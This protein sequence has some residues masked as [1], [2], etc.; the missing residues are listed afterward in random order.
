MS[1][2]V[3]Y[4]LRESTVLGQVIIEAYFFSARHRRPGGPPEPKP[5]G[6]TPEG[7]PWGGA[8][9][10]WRYYDPYGAHAFVSPPNRLM[11]AFGDTFERRLER[12]RA[13][14]RERAERVVRKGR[15]A[16]ARYLDAEATAMVAT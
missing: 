3:H 2:F 4:E 6:V 11:R 16:W 7:Y 1:E 5:H 12:A 8:P 9:A 13:H 15:A 14:V 10:C